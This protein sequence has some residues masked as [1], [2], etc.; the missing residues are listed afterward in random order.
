M[1]SVWVEK[2]E[3]AFGEQEVL[4]D[5][6]FTLQSGTRTGMVGPNGSGKTTLLRI[7]SGEADPDS[8]HVQYAGTPR[9][10]YLQQILPY[11]QDWTIWDTMLDV[12]KP[13]FAMENRL[14]ELERFMEVVHQADPDAYLRYGREY[15]ELMERFE[16]EGGYRYKSNI[17]GVLAGLGLKEESWQLPLS[18]LSG[19]QRSRVALARL[20]LE[21][22]DILLLDEPTNHL[23]LEAIAWLEGTLRAFRGT[24]LVVSHDRWFLDAICNRILEI[25][26]ATLTEY[27]GT[28]TDYLEQREER[29]RQQ[30]KA[31][32]LNQREIKRREAIIARYRSFNR[33]KSIKAAR[34]WEKRLDRM[35]RME[36]P[37]S[38]EAFRLQLHVDRHSGNDV[39]LTEDLGMEFPGKPLFSHLDLHLRLGERAALIGPNGIGKTTLLH[40][41]N[42]DLRQTQGAFLLGT[43]V[44]IGYYDQ[45]QENLSLDKTVL[46]EVWDA[47]PLMTHQEVRDHLGAFLFRGEDVDKKIA[48]LSGGERGR[49]SLLKLVLGGANFLLL[50]EPTNHLD[51]DSRQVLEEAL[52]DFP[53]TIL[54]VSHDR[55]FID[56]VANR[57]IEMKPD[58][59]VQYPGAWSEY[60]Y[61]QSLEKEDENEG[62]A[63][64]LTEQRKEKRRD[65]EARASQ[66]ARKQALKQAEDRVT[67][68]EELCAALEEQ[69]AAPETYKDPELRDQCTAQYRQAQADLEEAMERWMELGEEE[70]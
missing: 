21:Q 30:M 29:Y 65:R 57:V 33:E 49:V 5:I 59:F 68:L 24:L 17:Q 69:L 54:L 45:Q 66:R 37:K 31:Y 46:D 39:L 23:D 50:D 32:T 35:E 62:S 60:L 56:R 40:I 13:V 11:P 9:I 4:K 43:G 27:S 63:Q 20:L 38:H 51:I 26:N 1:I 58:S 6:T 44:K 10:G 70:E 36:R 8:G 61:H 55:Y 2:I 16:E 3:K 14:R 52:S 34:S 64:T 48:D 7:M 41:L 47:Y 42:G 25:S 22:P 67:Q 19:G 28:Y 12:Y 15:S 18:V 53:G